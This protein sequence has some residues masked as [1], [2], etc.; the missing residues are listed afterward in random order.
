MTFENVN[1]IFD[2]LFRCCHK[3]TLHNIIVFHMLKTSVSDIEI[4]PIYRF[5]MAHIMNEL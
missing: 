1:P 5:D 2:L 3:I 4:A